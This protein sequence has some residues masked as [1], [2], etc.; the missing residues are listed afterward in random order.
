MKKRQVALA[1]AICTALT[2]VGFVGNAFAAEKND[3][4]LMSF[5]LAEMVGH[6]QG[7]IAGEL[8]RARWM[9]G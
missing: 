4:D 3:D 6:G 9:V 2:S 5:N 7:V 8:V 1:A